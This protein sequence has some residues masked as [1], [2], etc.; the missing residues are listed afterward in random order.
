MLVIPWRLRDDELFREPPSKDLG[1]AAAYTILRCEIELLDIAPT[2]R[3][4]YALRGKAEFPS[5]LNC[6]LMSKSPV[7]SLVDVCRT[8]DIPV[9]IPLQD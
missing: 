4:K 2:P 5:A 7:E 9:P 6:L 3:F 8:M 1:I